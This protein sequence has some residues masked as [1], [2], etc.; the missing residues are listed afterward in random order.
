MVREGVGKGR[1][2]EE[3][4]FGVAVRLYSTVDTS[5]KGML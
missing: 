1:G 4:F 5:V 3:V 2:R